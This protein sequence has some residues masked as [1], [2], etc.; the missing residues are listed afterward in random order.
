MVKPFKTQPVTMSTNKSPGTCVTCFAI[1]STMALFQLKDAVVIQRYCDKC[2]PKASYESLKRW[3]T[4]GGEYRHWHARPSHASCRRLLWTFGS[5][6][7]CIRGLIRVVVFDVRS[8]SVPFPN[9]PADAK[10]D[11]KV[12]MIDPF[13]A[14]FLRQ[15]WHDQSPIHAIMCD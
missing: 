12:T 4:S 11:I 7:F 8:C 13:A 14:N 15:D 10:N 9:Y 6:N 1:A 2:L 3:R 5:Y